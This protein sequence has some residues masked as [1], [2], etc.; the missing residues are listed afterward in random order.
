M[1]RFA[2]ILGLFCVAVATGAAASGGSPSPQRAVPAEPTASATSSIP[3]EVSDNG[4]GKPWKLSADLDELSRLSVLSRSVGRP[5]TRS[6]ALPAGLSAEQHAGRLRLDDSGAVEVYVIAAEDASATLKELSSLGFTPHRIDAPSRTIQ[7]RIPV[8]ALS[9][10]AALNDVLSIGPPDYPEFNTGSVTTQGDALLHADELRNKLGVTGTGVKVGVIS[11]GIQG[12]AQS[13]STGDLP[14]TVDASTCDVTGGDP[15]AAAAGSEGTALLEIVHDLAPGAELW[16]GYFGAGTTTGGTSLDFMAAV[17]CLASHVDVVV[18]DLSFFNNGP[19]DGTSAVSKN[20]AAALN[21]PANP[22]RA[23]YTAVGNYAEFHYQDTY[24]SSGS[25]VASGT[26]PADTWTLHGFHATPSTQDSGVHVSC[27]VASSTYSCGDQVML[28][29]GGLMTVTLEWSD[30]FSSSTNDY[31]LLLLDEAA[32]QLYLASTSRQS[33]AGSHPTEAFTFQ[34]PYS[35]QSRFDIV[36]GNYRGQAAPRTLNMFIHCLGCQP[37]GSVSGYHNFNTASGSVPNNG[38]TAGGVASLGAVPA[39]AFIIEP[40]SSE[41]PTADG[42]TKPDAVA[43]DAVS[44][45]GAGGFGTTFFGTSA[46]APHAAG[47]AALLLSCNPDLRQGVGGTPPGLARSAL[48]TAVLGTGALLQ[49]QYY[50]A[51]TYGVGLPNAWQATG[52]AQ[53]QGEITTIRNMH[54]RD[55]ATSGSDHVYVV[56]DCTIHEFVAGVEATDHGPNNCGL[57]DPNHLAADDA[58]NLY[59]TDDAQCGVY[60]ISGTV[61]TTIAG[62]APGEMPRCYFAGDG[63][64]ATQASL[65][66]P[67]AIAIHNGNVYVADSLS[68]RV[69]EISGGVITTV[70]GDGD[71]YAYQPCLNS[72]DGGSALNASVRPFGLQVSSSGDLF[73]AS[74]CVVRKVTAGIISTIAGSDESGVNCTGSTGDGGPATAASLWAGGIALDSLGDL[75]IADA[76]DCNVR[77]VDTHGV[78]TTVAGIG[79]LQPGLACTYNGFDGYIGTTLGVATDA[80]AVAVDALGDLF[81]TEYQPFDTTLE[82]LVRI[83]RAS[84]RDLDGYGDDREVALGTTPTAYCS[85]MRADVTDDGTVNMIDLALL[86]RQFLKPVPSWYSRLDQNGNGVID[87]LDLS[88]VASQFLRS[89][90]SSCH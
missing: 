68:C 60:E 16:F 42:R 46:A 7:G 54:P 89:A 2:F 65:G 64:P 44:V 83:A 73:I 36:I 22:I 25:S 6:S 3:S 72:G 88:I 17:N 49:S 5:L 24:V 62:P 86:A 80:D 59:V 79:R 38:D 43:P 57:L 11:G 74:N 19:Y 77:K 1:S 87:M 81:I 13:Q 30:P 85:V 78:I 52:P 39:G 33:G 84:D 23:Y 20:A 4:L 51:N 9:T 50:P 37:F 29:P 69:R 8:D 82:G 15:T 14:A 63:G 56:D 48:H 70:A 10:A 61:L 32:G 76:D 58:G 75:Y 40:F 66:Y 67:G 34:N 26:N 35:A 41:G 27:P 53:C 31:D 21:N 71:P 90:A 55:V 28:S 47:I 18:D 12:L 45:S